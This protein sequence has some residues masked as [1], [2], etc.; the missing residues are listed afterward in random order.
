MLVVAATYW[1]EIRMKNWCS[2]CGAEKMLVSACCACHPSHL[3][4]NQCRLDKSPLE[5][6][7]YFRVFEGHLLTLALTVTQLQLPFTTFSHW[8]ENPLC[9]H[10]L[11]QRRNVYT[12]LYNEDAVFYSGSSHFFK[13]FFIHKYI[14]TLLYMSRGGTVG[15]LVE[16]C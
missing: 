4:C 7:S 13:N 1:K 15:N 12:V 8:T 6:E 2:C 16:G 3:C 10:R 9:I 11:M 5:Y 14:N